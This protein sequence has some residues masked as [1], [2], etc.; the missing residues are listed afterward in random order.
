[1]ENLELIIEN[2]RLGYIEKLLTECTNQEEL[3]R[4]VN[5]INESMHI[6]AEIL[7][8]DGWMNPSGSTWLDEVKPKD[9]L[10]TV[11]DKIS[12]SG[13]NADYSHIPGE[14]TVVNPSP[15]SGTPATPVV[16]PRVLN[17]NSSFGTNFRH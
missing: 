13:S 7:E 8:A 16:K 17:S 9:K 11:S 12:T 3:N 1:M 2:I 15:I 10:A 5:L 6:L 4:G 14:S